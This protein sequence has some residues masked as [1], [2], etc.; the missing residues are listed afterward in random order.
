MKKAYIGGLCMALCVASAEV[1]AA[2]ALP[3][4][5]GERIVFLGDSI[6]AQGVKA[7]G[8]VDLIQKQIATTRPSAG[9]EVIGAGISGNKVPDLQKRLDK[10]VLAKN[11]SVVV[12][13]IGVNDVWHW[14]KHSVG[15]KIE[16]YRT[17]LEEIIGK[18]QA[19][20]ARV[21]LCTPAVIGEAIPVLPDPLPDSAS[22][23]EK[24][25][26]HNRQADCE[27]ALMLDEYAA[28]SRSAAKQSGAEFLDLRRAFLDYLKENN[29]S[30]KT[31]G[32]LT[33]DGVHMN[34]E[35]N[36]FVAGLIADRLGLSGEKQP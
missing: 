15:T 12:I 25:Q 1:R 28:A 9:I 10:D 18:I 11:P 19:A 24:L 2:E 29:P 36:R 22:H 23:L 34:A 5:D 16:D 33:V 6:T 32:V 31:R 26:W 35:G 4:K 3:L 17:G 27:R 13:Y 30:N 7:G 14:E 20:K 8:Y 21:I